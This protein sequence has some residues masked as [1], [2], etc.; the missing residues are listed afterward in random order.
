MIWRWRSKISV[1]PSNLLLSGGLR[2]VASP[3]KSTGNATAQHSFSL[4]SL[5]NNHHRNCTQTTPNTKILTPQLVLSTLRDSPSDLFAL[6]FFLWCAGQPH[7]FH[8]KPAF[9]HMVSVLSNLTHR[10]GTVRGIVNELESVGC[11]RKAQTLLLLMRIY[12]C[13]GM[14]DMVLESF[15]EMY[16]YGY[17]PNTYARNI[18]MDVGFKIKNVDAALRVLEETKDPNFLSFSIAIYN[19]CRLYDADNAKT[20]LRCMLRRGYYMNP[21]TYAVVLNCFCKLGRL[22]EAIELLGM[23]IVLGVP[24]SVAAWS[25][26]INGFCK[27]GKI[28]LAACLLDKMVKVGC[29]PNIVTC[30]SLIKGLLEH[31]MLEK[32]Y[33]ILGIL[34]LK[35]CFPDLVLCNVLI[36]CF[37][38]MGQYTDALEVFSCLGEL[39]LTPDVYTLSSI[40]STICLSRQYELLPLLIS[41]HSIQPDLVVC[42][43]LL[44]YFCKAGY[45]TGAVEFYNDMLVRGFLPDKYTFAGVL[46]ALCRLGKTQAAVEMYHRILCSCGDIVDAQIHTI[47]IDGLIKSGR[48]HEAMSIFRDEKFPLD[49]LSYTVAID[50]LIKAGRMER[51]CALFD[52]MKKANVVPNKQVCNLMLSGFCKRGDIN[53]IKHVLQEIVARNIEIDCH[54]YNI[55]MSCS[56]DPHLVYSLILE[57]RSLGFLPKDDQWLRLANGHDN[58]AHANFVSSSIS[59]ETLDMSASSSDELLDSMALVG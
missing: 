48:Y 42:N 11:V 36:N 44:S 27:L 23:M 24:I 51:A 6:R 56:S 47:I 3:I 26:L 8:D 32:A 54:T 39:R 2:I 10:Y 19:L 18:V 9:R 5:T 43:C 28:E 31:N 37:S 35:G 13:G 7:Y 30:T 40:V 33:E 25:I 53:M 12:W 41:G 29:S 49:V 4:K 45:P 1:P 15:E 22:D 46:S 14:Y 38:K 52:Q 17:V 57:L 21:E 34:E 20:V 58:F 16:N 55:L 50:G 59:R